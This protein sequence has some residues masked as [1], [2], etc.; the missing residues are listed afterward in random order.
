MSGGVTDRHPL[1]QVFTP[2]AWKSKGQV[3]TK[4]KGKPMKKSIAQNSQ[5]RQAKKHC[6]GE[7]GKYVCRALVGCGF[8]RLRCYSVRPLGLP[9]VSL[10]H[11]PTTSSTSSSTLLV[12]LPAGAK[13]ISAYLQQC[14][15]AVVV[16]CC[17]DHSLR[18]EL[19]RLQIS[20][21]DHFR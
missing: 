12:F 6:T 9:V 18:G 10:A 19:P 13:M 8:G 11:L 20:V 3:P 15:S 1:G 16:S 5:F 4:R 17:R 2:E 21:Q 14:R 7:K